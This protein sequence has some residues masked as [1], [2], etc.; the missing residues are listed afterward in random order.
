VWYSEALADPEIQRKGQ[1]VWRRKMATAQP[2]RLTHFC[3]ILETRN[4]SY[5]FKASSE[6]AK[7]K[8]Q[9]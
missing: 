9:H 4:D 8:K 2:N 5:R 6:K 3:H 1:R 7:K